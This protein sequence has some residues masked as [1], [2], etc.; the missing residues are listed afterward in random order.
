MWNSSKSSSK[1]SHSSCF[2]AN[3]VLVCLLTWL[4]KLKKNKHL[5]RSFISWSLKKFCIE[6][7]INCIEI[8]CLLF[9]FEIGTSRN[10]KLAMET[11]QVWAL[12]HCWPGR[13]ERYKSC[14]NFYWVGQV[15]FFVKRVN[16][17]R[18]CKPVS[19]VAFP[20]Q[21]GIGCVWYSCIDDNVLQ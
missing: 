5:I 1:F 10:T 7:E 15:G 17:L 9:V 20:K 8:N 11:I 14:V 18:Y 12:R 19:G 3:S 4:K 6:I 16:L 21:T 13:E 2:S